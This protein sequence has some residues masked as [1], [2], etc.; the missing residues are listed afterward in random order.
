MLKVLK[1]MPVQD[2][3]LTMDSY[4]PFKFRSFE[5]QA[6]VPFYWRVGDFKKSLIEVGLNPESGAVGSITVTCYGGNTRVEATWQSEHPGV[7][8]VD[9]LPVCD[10]Q[11]WSPKEQYADRFIDETNPFQAVIG[12]DFVSFRLLSDKQVTR[13]YVV[14]QLCIG[15]DE[16]GHVCELAFRNLS[17]AEIEQASPRS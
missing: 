8:V 12:L 14:G 16:N 5:T 15:V 7:E 3:S 2:Y 13:V 17:K 10:I 9:G 11:D 4:V 6:S 1:S